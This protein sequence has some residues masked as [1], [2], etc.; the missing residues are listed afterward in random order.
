MGVTTD[1]KDLLAEQAEGWT[2][3][4]AEARVRTIASA[5][6]TCSNNFT[7]AVNRQAE[8]KA[9]YELKYNRALLDVRLRAQ[10]GPKWNQAEK[11]AHAENE[12]MEERRNQLAADAQVTALR[13]E[14][15]ALQHVMDSLRSRI[16]TLR[17]QM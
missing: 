1:I 3:P 7:E 5:L 15:D 16:A 10:A 9:D 17:Q 12:S 4:E 11:V 13:R 2:L 6:L 8:S 14:Q